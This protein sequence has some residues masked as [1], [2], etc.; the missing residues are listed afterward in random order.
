MLPPTIFHFVFVFALV[1]G[2]G[3]Y[4]RL[5]LEVPYSWRTHDWI[6]LYVFVEIREQT[7]LLGRDFYSFDLGVAL[8][9]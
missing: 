6:E 8:M 4:N 9:F 5:P 7:P 1:K 2:S 3:R